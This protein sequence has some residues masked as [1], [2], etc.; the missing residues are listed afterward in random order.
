MSAS[1]PSDDLAF[2]PDYSISIIYPH[3]TTGSIHCSASSGNPRITLAKCGLC[4]SSATHCQLKLLNLEILNLDN[5]TMKCITVD[6]F[7]SK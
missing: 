1:L 6:W 5:T 4:F 7:C 2:L 3:P